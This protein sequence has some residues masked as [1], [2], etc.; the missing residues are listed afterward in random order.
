MDDKFFWFHIIK[1]TFSP[2]SNESQFVYI[3]NYLQMHIF[4]QPH[5]YCFLTSA[6]AD[7]KSAAAMS[8]LC[9]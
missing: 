7:I 5:Y 4:H 9:I 6:T 1:H 2:L 8:L 3:K